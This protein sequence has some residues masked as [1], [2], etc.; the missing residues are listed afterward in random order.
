LVRSA[1]RRTLRAFRERLAGRGKK[2]KVILTAVARKL[3]VIANAVVR[4]GQSWRADGLSLI[5]GSA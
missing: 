2:P 1:A 3:L 5:A 4:S